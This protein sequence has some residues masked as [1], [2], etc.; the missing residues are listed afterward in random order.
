MNEIDGEIE[1]WMGL[2]NFVSTHRDGDWLYRARSEQVPYRGGR[3]RS[4][5]AS[6]VTDAEHGIYTANLLILHLVCRRE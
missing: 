4:P 5:A 3:E 1:D 2:A 6:T